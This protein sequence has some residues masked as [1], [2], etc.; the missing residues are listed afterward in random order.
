MLLQR[1]GGDMETIN[2][3]LDV[4]V[5]KR[6][7]SYAVPLVDDLNTVLTR[8]CDQW[9]R[10][11]LGQAL[12]E[13]RAFGRGAT[14]GDLQKLLRED[15]RDAAFS[16]TPASYA[17][18]SVSN[19]L[20]PL[21][22][23]EGLEKWATEL[24][25]PADES[26]IVK[27]L[28]ELRAADPSWGRDLFVQHKQFI[29]SRGV[30]LPVPMNIYADYMGR[31]ILAKVTERGIELNGETFNNPSKA[32]IAAKRFMG[33]EGT[34]ANTNGWHFW[35]VDLPTASGKPDTLNVFRN[36]LQ[37]GAPEDEPDE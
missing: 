13:G 18:G 37:H 12:A 16:G 29:T 14:G 33:A 32:A 3:R 20:A 35:V 15:E 10:V 4:E 21:P 9:D 19:D 8:L 6:L 26:R 28:R 2:V 22:T 34:A 27:R 17:G 31:R 23:R 36:A 5:F 25:S 30:A 24:D 11:A 7:Q 1:R